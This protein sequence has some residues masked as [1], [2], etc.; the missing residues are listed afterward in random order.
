V[1][2]RILDVH[3]QGRPDVVVGEASVSQTQRQSVRW[4]HAGHARTV[5]ESL[6]ERIDV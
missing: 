1:T 2:E 4:Q 5:A 3:L 6:S